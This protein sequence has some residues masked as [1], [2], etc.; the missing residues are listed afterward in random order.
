M[1]LRI[2]KAYDLCHHYLCYHHH[3][4]SLDRFIYN[5]TA[6]STSYLLI[7]PMHARTYVL[8]THLQ[9]HGGYLNMLLTQVNHVMETLRLDATNGHESVPQIEGEVA[10]YHNLY[11]DRNLDV[12]KD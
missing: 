3:H 11:Y 1:T 4:R 7:P 9:M 12:F 8:S 5:V 10:I 2:C 6:T